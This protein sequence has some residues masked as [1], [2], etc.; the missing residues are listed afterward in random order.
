MLIL[1]ILS[2]R[3]NSSLMKA[4]VIVIGG[5]AAG[6]MCAFVAG[7]RGRRVVVLEHNERVGR[8]IEI[9]GGGRCNFTNTGTTAGN[10][11]SRNPHFAK[12]ALAR[13]TPSDFVALVGRHRIGYHE[14]KL[15]QLFCDG[16]SRQIVEMLLAECDA[17]GVRVVAGCRVEG[18]SQDERFRVKTSRRACRSRSR[19]ATSR[20]SNP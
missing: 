11:I 5:G 14:K 20:P 13:Y 1:L 8:K 15:G 16:S 7:G 9:S 17:A 18:V 2:I 4:D 3:V 19:R 10:F 12:S 6:L